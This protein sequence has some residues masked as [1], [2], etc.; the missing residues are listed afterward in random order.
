MYSRNTGRNTVRASPSYTGA[1]RRIPAANGQIPCRIPPGYNGN[2]FSGGL[3]DAV[4]GKDTVPDIKHHTAPPL[5]IIPEA[6]SEERTAEEDELPT[7]V[8]ETPDIQAPSP[9]PVNSFITALKDR[10]SGDDLLLIVIILLLASEGEKSE[11][12]LFILTVL[13]LV[14]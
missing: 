2:L 9:D 11:L 10:V 1:G 5:P 12:I 8:H 14:N 7:A 6:D 13:L 3:H 4:S